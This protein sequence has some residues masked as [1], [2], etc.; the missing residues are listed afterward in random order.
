MAHE[1]EKF[2]FEDVDANYSRSELITGKP[3][4]TEPMR[5]GVRA[6]TITCKNADCGHNWRATP[7]DGPD[8]FVPTM[9]AIHVT[10]PQCGAAD[11]IHIGALLSP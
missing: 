7:G 1:T 8:Q 6:A 3:W 4:A 11:T 2:L 10:C 5:T 9:N